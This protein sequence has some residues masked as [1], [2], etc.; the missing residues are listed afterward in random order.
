MSLFGLLSIVAEDPQLQHALEYAGQP[1]STDADLVAPPAL[2][3]ILI[4]ALA[5]LSGG[6]ASTSGAGQPRFLL[7]ITATARE[8]ED[9]ASAL[10]SLLPDPHAAE[11]FPAWETLPHER[12]SP[13]PDTSGRRLAVLRRLVSPDYGDPRSGPLQ[14]VVTPIRTRASRPTS[15]TS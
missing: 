2:R 7:A 11:Y 10:N 4:A 12:L 8:A 1:G 6:G 9:L 14:V 15:R 13:R 3:P 5:A